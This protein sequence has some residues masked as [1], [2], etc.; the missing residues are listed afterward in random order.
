M[1][2]L[3]IPED[4]R[5]E[6]ASIQMSLGDMPTIRRPSVFFRHSCERLIPSNRHPPKTRR[7]PP[8]PPIDH[9]KFEIGHTYL[10]AKDANWDVVQGGGWATMQY[11]TGGDQFLFELDAHR[12]YAQ[13]DYTALYY[14]EPWGMPVRCLGSGMTNSHGDLHLMQAVDTGDLPASYDANYPTGAKIWLVVSTDVDCATERMT[15]WRPS[16]YL[17]ES[18]LITFDATSTSH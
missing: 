15:A 4:A 1:S 17:F 2:P 14:A 18:M 6:L 13:T 3:A 9:R 8:S 16:L 10:Y 5:R 7:N 12:L 11:R